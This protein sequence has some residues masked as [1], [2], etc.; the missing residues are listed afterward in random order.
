MMTAI[1]RRVR[2]N[3]LWILLIQA[4][5]YAGKIAVHPTAVTSWDEAM[6]RADVGPLPGE[7]MVAMGAVYVAAFIAIA[8]WSRLSDSRRGAARGTGQSG[9]MG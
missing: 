4:L 3:Y 9:S 1:G 2:R 8:V 7:V 5:A 6:A